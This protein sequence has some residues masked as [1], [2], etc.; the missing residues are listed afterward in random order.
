[1]L[2]KICLFVKKNYIK[3]S[4]VAL[5]FGINIT[6]TSL[7]Y[8]HLFGALKFSNQYGITYSYGQWGDY[9]YS[10]SITAGINAW[11]SSAARIYVKPTTETYGDIRIFSTDWGTTGW[12]GQST[13]PNITSPNTST[14]KINDRYRTSFINDQAELVAHELGH[15]FTLGHSGNKTLMLPSGYKGSATPTQDDIDG[16]NAKY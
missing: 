5:I 2:K 16:V 13:A 12:H 11:N 8:T 6:S 7:A 14:I 10:S 3:I 1:M 15:S 4:L 9:N